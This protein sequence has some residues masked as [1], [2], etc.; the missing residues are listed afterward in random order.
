MIKPEV[1][2]EP[3]NTAD[4]EDDYDFAPE[5]LPEGMVLDWCAGYCP[6]QAEGT[7]DGKAFYFRARHQSWQFHVAKDRTHRFVNDIFYC[8]I[9]WPAEEFAAGWMSP[10]DVLKC[11]H[12][13]VALYR[14]QE[15]QQ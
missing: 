11:L 5:S 4:A 12:L 10:V 13:G 8:D 2:W 1:D 14:Q 6:V 3:T 7:I 15:S 9:D